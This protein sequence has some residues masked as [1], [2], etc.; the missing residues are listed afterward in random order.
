MQSVHDKTISRHEDMEIIFEDAICNLD[1]ALEKND[2]LTS[3]IKDNI[4]IF[5]CIYFYNDEEFDVIV[6]A[7]SVEVKEGYFVKKIFNK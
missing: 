1:G 7:S 6:N 2:I 3:K 5:H 4:I